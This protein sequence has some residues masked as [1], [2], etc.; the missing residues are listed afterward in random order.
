MK[1]NFRIDYLDYSIA[2]KERR[3]LMACPGDGSCLRQAGSVNSY[4]R[5]WPCN[6][7]CTTKKCPNWVFCGYKVP[8]WL[9]YC[10][11]GHCAECAIGGNCPELTVVQGG[12]IP[13]PT[14]LKSFFRQI[15]L[16]DANLHNLIKSFLERKCSVCHEKNALDL[17]E[18]SKFSIERNPKLKKKIHY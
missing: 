14:S 3:A 10:Y 18:Y 16:P 7:Q 15:R 11:G 4:V 8:E 17:S 5:E 9:L 2:S 6:F 12:S 1:K 13:T